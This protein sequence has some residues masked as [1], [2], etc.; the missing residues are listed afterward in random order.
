M[1]PSPTP[2][3]AAEI[4][5]LAGVTRATVS[6]WRRRHAD[7][8]APVGGTASS[9]AYDLQAVR[10]WL[11]ARNQLPQVTAAEA[12]REQLRSLPPHADLAGLAR[13]VV[14]ASGLSG[15][16]RELLELSDGALMER[17]ATL[18]AA[19]AA[20]PAKGGG[21]DLRA[22]NAAVVRGVLGCVAERGPRET[23][24]VL[25]E[26]SIPVGSVE[27][28]P[29]WLAELMVDVVVRAGVRAGA[30]ILDP[31]CGAGTILSAAAG[32]GFGQIYGQDLSPTH[33]GY[34]VAGVRMSAPAA[35]V[36][37]VAGDSIRADGFPGLGVDAVVCAPPFG[38]R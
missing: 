32:R 5:R 22:G 29:P 14:A 6:N 23:L 19:D 7:F 37:V 3:T 2:V 31:A 26:R 35:K 28:L 21:T 25:A 11:A 20:G 13:V 38:D 34:A 15:I 30:S 27:Y 18:T 33:A 10:D 16:G 8:P 9:P 17:V 1:T 4:S 24:D 12:L 36:Q